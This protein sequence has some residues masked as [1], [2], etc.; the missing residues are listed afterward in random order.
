MQD[1][2]TRA[3]THI[4]VHTIIKSIKTVY[5]QKSNFR[6]DEFALFLVAMTVYEEYSFRNIS[7]LFQVH[8]RK[9]GCFS[10]L[11]TDILV[12]LIC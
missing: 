11:L 7:A 9:A 6:A 3:H 2:H 1:I 12:L 5:T 4:C 10:T 8:R